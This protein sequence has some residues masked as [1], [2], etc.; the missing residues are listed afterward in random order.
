M[1][2]I[3]L[4][5]ESNAPLRA[6]S[7]ILGCYK[8]EPESLVNALSMRELE[9]FPALVDRPAVQPPL[10]ANSYRRVFKHHFQFHPL[11]ANPTAVNE[12]EFPERKDHPN[13]H[14]SFIPLA[15]A[16][17]ATRS[18]HV[19]SHHQTLERDEADRCWRTL[20]ELR[21]LRQ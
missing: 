2:S 13:L 20:R 18:Q 1:D 7:N 10:Q 8:L 15:D 19:G 3:S 16:A 17:R 11:N 5:S 9:P 14:D 4:G 6:I 21:C 12:H